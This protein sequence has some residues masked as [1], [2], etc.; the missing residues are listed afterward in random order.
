MTEPEFPEQDE[1]ECW[2][3]IIVSISETE[4]QCTGCLRIW[5]KEEG[6]K[7][8]WPQHDRG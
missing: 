6:F 8:D 3:T 1:F 2:H 4:C 7:S 5:P